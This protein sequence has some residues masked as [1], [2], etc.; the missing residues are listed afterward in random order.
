MFPF[1]RRRRACAPRKPI[2]SYRPSF[3]QLED[4]LTPAV[5]DLTT[6]NSSGLING[7]IFL[8]CD[9]PGS[10]GTGQ[11]NSFVKIR[12]SGSERGY[13]TTGVEEFDSS[14]SKAVRVNDLPTITVGGIQYRE[15]LV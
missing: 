5:L 8:Q 11:L 13:N 2:Q 4:R 1:S 9:P 3:E 14:A 7:A 6:L 12:A 10:T 15:L